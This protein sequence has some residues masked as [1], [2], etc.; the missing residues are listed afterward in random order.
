MLGPTTWAVENRGSSTVKSGGVAHHLD[1]QVA[2][3]HQPAVEDGHPG[4]RLALAKDRQSGMRIGVELLQRQVRAEGMS[5]DPAHRRWSIERTRASSISSMRSCARRGPCRGHRATAPHPAAHPSDDRPRDHQQRHDQDALDQP[6]DFLS[7]GG[8]GKGEGED[9]ERR[10]AH[11][12][13][14]AS[15]TDR[16]VERPRPRPERTGIHRER[17]A[18]GMA[19]RQDEHADEQARMPAT[20]QPADT[21]RL[22]KGR[23]VLAEPRD[24]LVRRQRAVGEAGRDP[25]LLDERVG[26]A[27][28][29]GRQREDGPD[30]RRWR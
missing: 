17:H 25:C 11:G 14:R 5:R 20:A 6:H 13:R 10:D 19:D 16:P 1:A 26:E 3:R 8:H 30:R 18:V 2:P 7:L 4:D 28:R 22:A 23:E 24:G 12:R 21:A 15:S 9:R 29:V 27:G